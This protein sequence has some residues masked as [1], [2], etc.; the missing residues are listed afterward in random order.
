MCLKFDYMTVINFAEYKQ[1][2][3]REKAKVNAL[4]K[5]SNIKRPNDVNKFN[6]DFYKLV[7]LFMQEHYPDYGWRF[8]IWLDKIGKNN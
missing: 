8:D 7:D 2:Q 3:E 1:K 6:H 4:A 5:V